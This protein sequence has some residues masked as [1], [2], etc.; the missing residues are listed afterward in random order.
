MILLIET[1]FRHGH[2]K[3]SKRDLAI[4]TSRLPIRQPTVSPIVNGTEA[5]SLRLLN[6][7]SNADDHGVNVALPPKTWLRFGCRIVQLE[8]EQFHASFNRNTVKGKV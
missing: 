4:R 5:T 8:C 1:P 3:V 7:S 6:A 2:G